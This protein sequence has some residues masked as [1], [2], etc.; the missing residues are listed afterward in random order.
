M[1]EGDVRWRAFEDALISWTNELAAKIR[2]AGVARAW[3]WGRRCINPGH[4][5]FDQREYMAASDTV[6]GSAF[7]LPTFLAVRQ[8][9]YGSPLAIHFNKVIGP[10]STTSIVN[11]EDF[12]FR[13]AGDAIRLEDN[14]RVAVDHHIVQQRVLD[15]RSAAEGET[16]ESEILVLIRGQGGNRSDGRSSR[17]SDS[18]ALLRGLLGMTANRFVLVLLFGFVLIY[19]PARFFSA[20]AWPARIGIQQSAGIVI[21]AIGAAIALWCVSNFALIGRGTPAPFA[22]PR[23]LVTRGPY[24][25]VRNPMYIGVGTF[26]IGAAVFYQSVLFLAYAVLFFVSSHLFV[27]L[28]EE[29]TLRRTFGDKYTVYCG[30]VRRWTPRLP[31]SP[32]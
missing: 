12:A 8:S 17:S 31:P 14:G 3:R 25:F 15:L 16:A 11:P 6:W 7:H 28:Y 19:L 27:V 21:C 29:P 20:I 13:T 32:K 4:F 1:T 2:E 30:G 22:A 26:F 24:Q 9:I 23:R 10:R 18:P 5:I